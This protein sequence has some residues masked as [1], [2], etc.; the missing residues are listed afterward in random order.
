LL[1]NSATQIRKLVEE[2]VTRLLE[3]RIE[4]S[5][6]IVGGSAL[7]L[8]YPNDNAVRA[9]ADI[10]ALIGDEPEIAEVIFEMATRH[11][12][13]SN[14][15]N[16]N[17][18]PWI[19]REHIQLNDTDEMFTVATPRELIAMKMARLAEQ[20]LFDLEIICRNEK[21]K[22]PKYLVEVALKLAGEESVTNTFTPE[23]LLSVAIEVTDRVW[24]KKS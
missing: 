4:H 20:D 12:L 14:W 10:D 16:Q 1:F 11:N 6:H 22:D 8:R 23:D 21:I 13:P 5:I 2:L 19:L 9:T 18:K 17:A 3:K 24:K 15:I 7:A